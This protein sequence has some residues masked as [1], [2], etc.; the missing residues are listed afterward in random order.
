MKTLTIE[1][2]VRKSHI[3]N[4]IESESD[5]CP[6]ALALKAM[7]FTPF[8]ETSFITAS[9]RGKNFRVS[10]LPIRVA[11]FIENFD[12]GLLVKPF[13]FKLKMEEI[14]GK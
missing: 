6:V 13:K 14:E 8:V 3:D 2:N 7:R 11:K 1:V 4:G 5:G 9:R 12:S 10:Q